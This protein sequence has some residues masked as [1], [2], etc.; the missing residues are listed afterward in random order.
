MGAERVT[1]PR[2]FETS[3]LRVEAI[4]TVRLE[5]EINSL[6]TSPMP[7]PPKTRMSSLDEPPLSLIGMILPR[8][9]STGFKLSIALPKTT[10]MKIANRV[11]TY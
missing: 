6:L 9:F 4:F 2:K 1:E 7:G 5:R 11:E 3:R 10:L 8:I